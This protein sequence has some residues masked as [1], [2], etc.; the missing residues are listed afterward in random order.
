MRILCALLLVCTCALAVSCTTPCEEPDAL[1][2][3]IF[4]DVGQGD[5]ILLRTK[6]GD[7]LIDAGT[8]SSQER[9]CRKLESLGVKELALVIFTHTDEDHIGGADGVLAR[10]RAKR[11]WA[12]PLDA[13]SESCKRLA[14]VCKGQNLHTVCEWDIATVGG[15]G[16]FALAPMEGVTLSDANDNGIVLKV[17][18]GDAS[19]LFTGDV[20]EKCEKILVE[21]YGALHLDC[22]LYKVGHHGASD[23]NS[24]VLLDAASPTWAVVSCGAGNS[25]GHPHGA[26]LLRLRKRGIRVLRTDV[27]GD[28]EF[29]CDGKDFFPIIKD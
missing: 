16:F 22:D 7:V 23:S 20:S 13:D 11:V 6:G 10:F 18:C 17:T 26:T 27:A 2:H 9:L 8:E 28:I 24:E 14:E 29:T 12:P 1:L 15:V 5:C 19:A 21:R 25:Y 3:V 4:F